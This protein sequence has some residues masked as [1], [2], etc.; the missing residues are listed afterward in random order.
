MK[1]N[2]NKFMKFPWEVTHRHSDWSDDPGGYFMIVNSEGEWLFMGNN[3]SKDIV[4]AVNSLYE[5]ALSPHKEE[6][7]LC[8]MV[9][10]CLCKSCATIRRTRDIPLWIDGPLGYPVTEDWNYWTPQTP[11][12]KW[13]SF[14]FKD[15]KMNE[16]QRISDGWFTRQEAQ[17]SCELHRLNIREKK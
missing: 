6:N 8:D 10:S 5:A 16:M 13:R 4:D 14:F 1:E 11:D 3:D 9:R 15:A 2:N 17:H 7:P 12:G